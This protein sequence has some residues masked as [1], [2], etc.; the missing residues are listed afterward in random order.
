MR[1]RRSDAALPTWTRPP[2]TSSGSS[3][4]PRA[5]RTPG[6]GDPGSS[7]VRPD[8]MPVPVAISRRVSPGR[9]TEYAW[10]RPIQWARYLVNTKDIRLTM[11]QCPPESDAAF[12]SNSSSLNGPVPGSSYAGACMQFATGDPEV[13][14]T[15]MGGGI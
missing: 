2:A 7:H 3:I 6:L 1:G 10:D 9:L 12:F 11:R 8:A 14:V 4:L 15:T 13:A 5:R